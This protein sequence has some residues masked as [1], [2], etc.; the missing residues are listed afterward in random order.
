M[1]LLILGGGGMLGHKLWQTAAP[2][3]DTWAT[4]RDAGQGLPEGFDRSRIVSG[5]D[6][7]HFDSVVRAFAEVRPEAVVSCIGIVKQRT[8]AGDAR[9]SVAINSLFPHRLKALCAASGARLVH[10]STDCVFSGERGGYRE[11]DHADASDLYGRTKYLGEVSGPGCLTLRTSIIGR[12]LATSHGLVE[13][14]LK[15]RGSAP[16][17][18]N[19]RFSGVTTSEL[20][21]VIVSVIEQ[22]PA[23]SGVYHVAAEPISKFELLSRF[24]DVLRRGLTIREDPSLRIDRSLDGR[25][26][27]AATGYAP[28]DWTSMLTELSREVPIYDMWRSNAC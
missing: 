11:S 4:L 12:E 24:N 25:R 15:Q 9:V 5:V 28:P 14:F 8:G 7:E 16:G 3:L 13:W 2:R 6:A 18:T 22:H 23:L 27:S 19:A 17:Y 26:F 10:I 20:S 1:R 21:R